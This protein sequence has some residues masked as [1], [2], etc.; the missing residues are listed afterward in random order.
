[1]SVFKRSQLVMLPSNEKATRGE[2]YFTVEGRLAI[3]YST[4]ETVGEITQ[5]LYFLSDD[6]IKEGDWCYDENTKEIGKFKG[7]SKYT[8]LNAAIKIFNKPKKVIATTNT[9]LL[10][11][12]YT[13]R[14]EDVASIRT[15]FP[16]PSTSFIEKFV[17]SYNSGTPITEVMVEYETRT[18]VGNVLIKD[19]EDYNFYTKECMDM[20]DVL[21]IDKNNTIT[22]KKVKDSWS[23]EE[24]IALIKSAVTNEYGSLVDIH[25][26]WMGDILDW[27][28]ITLNKVNFDKFI[29]ENL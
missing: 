24:V 7:W 5:H 23:R 18:L 19:K 21:K 11:T 6:E 15:K 27:R 9:S 14:A 12:P 1:M 16:Q 25:D 26:H 13:W 3:C 28:E 22:I 17:E 8:H 2:L 10:I 29:E 20:L 4:Y